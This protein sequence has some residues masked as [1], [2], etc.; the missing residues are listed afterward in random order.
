MREETSVLGPGNK[1]RDEAN[2]LST[3]GQRSRSLFFIGVVLLGLAF[4]VLVGGML[5]LG[6]KPTVAPA[7]WV[8]GKK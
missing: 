4:G 8:G 6:F 1:Y 3:L 7:V 2:D 5:I